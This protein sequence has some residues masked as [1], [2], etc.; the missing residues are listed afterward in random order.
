M[1]AIQDYVRNTNSSN[2]FTAEV[3]VDLAKLKAGT[4]EV[5]L[6]DALPKGK[7]ILGGG[8]TNLKNDLGGGTT[9]YQLTVGSTALTTATATAG[10]KGKALVK[11]LADGAVLPAD[12]DKVLVKIIA[13]NSA[14]TGALVANIIYM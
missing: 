9:T 6:T 5:D 4:T 10:L 12:T 2:I 8:L 13:G 1:M 3:L 14:P 11:F 7:L